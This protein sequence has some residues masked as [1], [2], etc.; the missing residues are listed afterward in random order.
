MAVP[1]LCRQARS[2]AIKQ[3]HPVS[4]SSLVVHWNL[5]REFANKKMGLPRVYF[6]MTVDNVPAGRI[7]MEV[8]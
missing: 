2:L 3:S 1:L 8:S 6:D 7:V 4:Q 5:I